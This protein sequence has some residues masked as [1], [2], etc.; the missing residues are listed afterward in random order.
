MHL[1][2]TL[3]ASGKRSYTLKKATT[4][5][6]ITKSAHPARFSPDDKYSRQRVTLKRR[7]GILPTQQA[8]IAV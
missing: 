7:F 8:D 5:G 4:T 3:D 6:E 1:M 2:Y